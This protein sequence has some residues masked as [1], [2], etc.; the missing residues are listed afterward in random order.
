MK[1][2]F[3]GILLST[4]CLPI[5]GKA[6]Q[7]TTP[8]TV[9]LLP[10]HVSQINAHQVSQVWLE[11]TGATTFNSRVGP[12]RDIPVGGDPTTTL[13][14]EQWSQVKADQAQQEANATCHL[15]KRCWQNSSCA[16]V[17]YFYWPAPSKN[18]P[19]EVVSTVT[20]ALMEAQ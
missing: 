19:A 15:V 14:P 1:K 2:I 13:C 3:F 16:W 17:M 8:A 10:E 6:Q 9:T 12:I 5:F 4:F 11:R 18:C 7:S 20:D